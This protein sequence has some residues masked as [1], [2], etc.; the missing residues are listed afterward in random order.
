MIARVDT[1]TNQYERMRVRVTNTDSNGQPVT[2]ELSIVYEGDRH[3]ILVEDDGTANVP[4]DVGNYLVSND[5]YSV[6][7]ADEYEDESATQSE[8]D[9][10][11]PD[12]ETAA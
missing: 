4:E 12:D 8:S 5:S 1:Q 2:S 10:D 7:Q 3:E 11:A 6:E 9:E